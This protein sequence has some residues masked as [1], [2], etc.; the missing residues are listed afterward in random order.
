ML[1]KIHYVKPS[2]QAKEHQKHA[3]RSQQL[4]DMVSD[5][6]RRQAIIQ[7]ARQL[8]ISQ[9]FSKQD[10][11]KANFL[12]SRQK[13]FHNSRS[14]TGAICSSRKTR[15]IEKRAGQSPK[16]F[17]NIQ[18]SRQPELFEQPYQQPGDN[19]KDAT[20]FHDS[21]KSQSV[22]ETAARAILEND[23]AYQQV[24]AREAEQQTIFNV[25]TGTDFHPKKEKATRKSKMAGGHSLL[26]KPFGKQGAMAKNFKKINASNVHHTSN[27]DSVF[28]NTQSYDA[29]E[30]TGE[31]GQQQNQVHTLSKEYVANTHGV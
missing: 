23:Q 31:E 6:S 14:V 10:R 3:Q 9:D 2:V 26:G 30:K 28:N 24:S 5:G 20:I 4:K 25:K 17:L 13:A 18:T 15:S 16:G 8:I 27:F 11:R 12:P 7:A 22:T 1:K 19:M 21:V 29:T